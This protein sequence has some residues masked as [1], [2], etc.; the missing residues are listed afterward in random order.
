MT[1]VQNS[2]DPRYQVKDVPVQKRRKWVR[3]LADLEVEFV[4]V[5]GTLPVC[6]AMIR[7]ISC[8]GVRLVSIVPLE[9][10]TTIRMR[11]KSVREGRVV[12]ASRE[13]TGQWSMGCAFSEEITSTDL[14]QLL[15]SHS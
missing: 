6:S 1:V 9:F 12:H 11:L 5:S 14:Q 8:G 13:S 4:P 3:W 10:G 7:D 2:P 15:V